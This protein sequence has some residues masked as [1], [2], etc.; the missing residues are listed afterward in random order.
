MIGKA[1]NADVVA[2]GI[3]STQAR[4]PGPILRFERFCLDV[5]YNIFL[6]P[7]LY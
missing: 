5:I 6:L 2:S 3:A 1:T 4:L 7:L